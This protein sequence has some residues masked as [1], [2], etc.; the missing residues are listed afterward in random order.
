MQC[1]N[2]RIVVQVIF[3]CSAV[4]FFAYLGFCV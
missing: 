4:V 3:L 2:A 1:N